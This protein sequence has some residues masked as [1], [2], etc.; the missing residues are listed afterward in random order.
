M[1]FAEWLAR[2]GTVGET[3]RTVGQQYLALKRENPQDDDAKIFGS[4]IMVRGKAVRYPFDQFSALV[5][6]A[7]NARSLTEFVTDIVL[8]E[9]NQTASELGER[10]LQAIVGAVATELAKLGL[11]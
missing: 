5:S 7:A 3:A 2:K 6:A 10:P 4:I 1:G 9:S 8:V 11:E